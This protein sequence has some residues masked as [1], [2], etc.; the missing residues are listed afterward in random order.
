MRRHSS[1]P[2]RRP[3]ERGAILI[4]TLLVAAF[5][6]LALGSYLSLNLSSARLAYR[7]YHASTA[8]NLAE[9]GAEE[10]LWSF[11]RTAAGT[12]GAWDGWTTSGTQAW[13]KFTDFTLNANT[14]GWV[15]V[16]VDHQNPTGG[17]RPK[18]VALS[19][20]EP[21]GE[22]P[23]IKML[24]VTLQHRSFFAGG[25]VAKRSV[26]FRGNNTSVD[27][28]DSDPDRNPATASVPYSATVRQDHGSVASTSVLNAAVSVN[29]ANVWGYVS[30]GGALP[31]VGSNGSIRGRNTPEGVAIDPSRVSTDFNA[32]FPT[33]KAP[34]DGTP[35]A[36]I[37]NT[38]TLGTA[39]LATKWRCPGVALAGND[40]LTIRG[41]V[42]LILTAGSGSD[43]LTLTGKSELIIPPGSSLVL[44]AEGDVKIA[45]NGI[46]NAN[47]APLSFIVWGVNTSNAGQ[48]IQLAG[49]GA[50]KAVVYAPNA[51]VTINGNG[52][53]MGSII[54][55]T[56]TLTGNAAF[57]YD[58]ALIDYGPNQPLGVTRW[59]ELTSAQA[60]APYLPKFQG[61]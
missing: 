46:T 22:A 51:A 17:V 40:T 27:S 36:A 21:P 53:A 59:R 43:A 58:E 11:N 23:V 34:T 6:A 25:L 20:I 38:T 31:E 48:E 12:T 13:R 37:N 47:A 14:T 30:T 32:D 24:E 35:I 4:V 33:V 45:G 39:G 56:I 55:D 3:R 41:V 19:S 8:F 16:Y 50:L 5:I 26:E 42:T 29:Q 49:N 10:A 9:A 28:W 2:D 44:Y 60:R 7:S 15:K 54:A 18:I 61:W 52:D 1:S 57:H